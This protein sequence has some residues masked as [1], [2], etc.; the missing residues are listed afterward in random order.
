MESKE[1][2]SGIILH[3]RQQG[4]QSACLPLNHGAY[5]VVRCGEQG[6][7]VIMVHVR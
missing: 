1:P 2:T 6:A 7:H 3:V 5:Y 4:V